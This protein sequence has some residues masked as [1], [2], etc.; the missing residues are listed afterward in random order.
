LR[1]LYSTF[2]GGLPGVGLLLLR[3]AIGTRLIL[4]TY[5]RV[6]GQQSVDAG[7][8]SLEL[9]ALAV[10]IA[11]ILGFGTPL[12]SAFSALAGIAVHV[13][14]PSPDPSIVSLLSFNTIV[15]TTAIA[16]LGPGAL[17]LD[18]R[19]FGRRKIIIPRVP[20]S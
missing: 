15:V 19:F 4:R 1:R 5:T 7:M 17:S 14:H 3:A 13:W 9:L 6:F 20:N 11:F 16:L 10:G 2:P 12:A 18:A 8:W